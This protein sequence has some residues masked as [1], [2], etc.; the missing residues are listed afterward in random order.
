VNKRLNVYDK[1]MRHNIYLTKVHN[2][3]EKILIK[4]ALEGSNGNKGVFNPK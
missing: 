2:A 1:I 4:S 3:S